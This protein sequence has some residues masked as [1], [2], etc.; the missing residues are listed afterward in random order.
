M[1]TRK[2]LLIVYHSLTGGT[3]QM[4][5]AARDGAGAEPAVGG[6]LLHAA[7]AGPQGKLAAAG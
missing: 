7:Q 3:R 6:R 2:T 1:D 5:E 4:A